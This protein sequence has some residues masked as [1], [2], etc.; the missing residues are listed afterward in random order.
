[1]KKPVQRVPE[2]FFAEHERLKQA[3]RRKDRRDLA[4][5]K[6]SPKELLEKNALFIG[7]D[8]DVDLDSSSLS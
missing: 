3:A 5:G 2:S 4:S 6:I 7:F 8:S 1:M